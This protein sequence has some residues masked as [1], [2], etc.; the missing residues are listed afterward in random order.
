MLLESCNRV[1]E[2]LAFQ[3]VPARLNL[4]AIQA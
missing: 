2:S 3:I 4:E 1:D